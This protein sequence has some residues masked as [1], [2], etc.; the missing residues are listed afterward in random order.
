MGPAAQLAAVAA[1]IDYAY[2]LA[3]LFIEHRNDA[4][5]RYILQRHFGG[6]DLRI[7]A[8]LGIHGGFDVGQLLR[9]QRLVTV[10]VKTHALIGDIGARLMNGG[11]DQGAQR[12][13]QQVCCRVMTLNMMAPF[14]IDLSREFQALAQTARADTAHVHDQPLGGALRVAHLKA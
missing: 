7:L 4:G 14:D 9:S 12:P 1:H 3:V 6:G 8:N 11:I 5:S 2:A 10:E 13:V